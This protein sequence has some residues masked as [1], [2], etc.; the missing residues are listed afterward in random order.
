MQVIKTDGSLVPFQPNKARQWVSWAARDVAPDA[1]AHMEHDILT[2]TLSRLSTSKVSTEQIHQTMIKVCLDKEDIQYSRVAAEL[3]RATILKNQERLLGVLSPESVPFYEIMDVLEQE[4]IWAGDWLTDPDLISLEDVIEQWY[5][6]LEAE[7]LEYWTVKQW[8]DKYSQKRNKQA[9]ET[10]AQGILALAISLHGVTDLAIGLA[11]GIIQGK[12]NMPTPVLNGCRNGNYDSISC[13][14]IEGG[15]SVDSMEVAEHIASKMTSKKAGIGI[16]LNCRSKGDDVK[17]GSVEHLGKAPIYA[18]VEKAVKKYTQ[19]TRGGSATVAFKV[20]DPDIMEMLMWKTQ[21]I[22]LAQR[23]DKVDY[24][25]VFNDAFALA[26]IKDE[27]WYTFS[28]YDAPEVHANFHSPQY[29]H[30]VKEALRAGKPHKKFKAIDILDAFIDSRHEHG[31][32]YPLNITEANLHTPF[33]DIIS[34]SNLCMEILLP[35]KPFTDMFDL[36]WKERDADGEVAFCAI[37]AINAQKTTTEEYPYIARVTL[38]T[39]DRMI[40]LAPAM[41]PVMKQAMVERR[42]VGIGITGL[43]GALYE[44]GLD[45]D[46]SEESLE[47]VETLAELHYYMLLKASQQMSKETG[48]VVEGVDFNWLPI[49]TMKSKRPPLLD[50]EALR[51]IAR[52][53]SVLVAHMPTESSAVFSGAT[54]G[55][56][57]S[58]R[59]VVYKKARQG[60]V[61]F[62]SEFFFEDTHIS[63][64]DVDMIPYYAVIQGYTDQA[65]SADFYTDFSKYPNEKLPREVAYEWF[66]AFAFSGIKTAYYQNFND[67]T[68]DNQQQVVIE[69]EEDCEGCKL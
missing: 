65:I 32:L 69:D 68:T 36:Y 59:R 62:I 61:Q 42:S 9:I 43:A 2:E 33:Y 52:M 28:I 31:R 53:H 38:E 7:P 54:N 35:T 49:D 29:M 24:D 45:Y 8:S 56:Y 66:F 17:G 22:D 63:V 57:P 23:I 64:W 16:T 41:T 48:V 39:V 18:S 46:G 40:E 6:E 55:V 13:C 47:F 34:Q 30:Y 5:I 50:W 67:N 27:H 20:I 37:A 21:R 51:G 19:Q 12:I 11:R 58:R 25:F 1:K 10:P 4:E 3:E 26:A 14:L 60:K 15:D 44:R